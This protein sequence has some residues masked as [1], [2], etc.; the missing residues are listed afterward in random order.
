MRTRTLAA[1]AFALLLTTAGCSALTGSP[2][3]GDG[4]DTDLSSVTYPDGA[5]PDGITNATLVLETHQ[6]QL[7]TD[8]YRLAFNLSHSAQGQMTNT[9]TIV[10]SNESQARQRLTAD[11]ERQTLDTY[12]NS[13]V[14]ATQVRSPSNTTYTSSELLR[15]TSQV[16]YEGARPGQLLTTIVSVG[17]YTATG[18]E[19]QNDHTVV[20]YEATGVRANASGQIPDAVGSVNASVAIDQEGRIWEATLIASGTTNNATE[21]YY[22][23]YRTMAVGDVTVQEPDWLANATA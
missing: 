13:E 3:N 20:R 1:V 12:V 19:N 16:H 2:E 11:L 9:T 22:Q 15:S 14:I 6:E 8:S 17:N 5:G 4:D 18:V 23:Q 10:V 7:A 21:I